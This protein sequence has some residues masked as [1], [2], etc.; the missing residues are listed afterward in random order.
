[1][2][3]GLRPRGRRARHNLKVRRNSAAWNTGCLDP[4]RRYVLLLFGRIASA[5]AFGALLAQV[6]SNDPAPLFRLL[7]WRVLSSDPKKEPAK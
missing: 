4:L 5:L 1:M 3:G 7:G 2:A 6:L